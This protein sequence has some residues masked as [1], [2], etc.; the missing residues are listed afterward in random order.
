MIGKLAKK[1]FGSRNQRILAR[2]KKQLGAIN[3]FEP[4]MQALSD[5]QLQQKL[6]NC[7]TNMLLEVH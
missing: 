5:Q 7:A 4:V 3:A 6:R 2:Y 1:I